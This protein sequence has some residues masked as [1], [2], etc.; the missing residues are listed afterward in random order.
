[1]IIIKFEYLKDFQDQDHSKTSWVSKWKIKSIKKGRR[2][3]SLKKPK[4]LSHDWSKK[5]AQIPPPLSV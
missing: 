2:N 1:M 5:S 4:Y 3:L